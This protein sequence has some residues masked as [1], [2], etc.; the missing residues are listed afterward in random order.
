[1]GTVKPGVLCCVLVAYVA[2]A[3]KPEPFVTADMTP[4]TRAEPA[5]KSTLATFVMQPICRDLQLPDYPESLVGLNLP[6]VT[7]TASLT[8]RKDGTAGE[9]SATVEGPSEQAHLFVEA[10][11]VA[12]AA[13]R[14]EP[15]ARPPRPG[16][17]DLSPTPVDYRTKVEFVFYSDKSQHEDAVT[18]GFQ[19]EDQQ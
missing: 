1:M 11:E 5:R 6:P 15:A 19:P 16:S 4:E 9:Y 7:L 8:I 2:C 12:V 14:C 18:M 13:W 10:A 3:Q 17:E